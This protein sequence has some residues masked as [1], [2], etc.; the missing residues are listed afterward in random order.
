VFS[1]LSLGLFRFL[2][3][4]FNNCLMLLSRRLSYVLVMCLIDLLRMGFSNGLLMDFSN[5]LSMIL[6]NGLRM[7]L[8]NGLRVFLDDVLSNGLRMNFDDVLSNGLRVSLSFVLMM[9]LSNGL[10][11]SLSYVLMM[12]LSNGLRVNLSYVLLVCFSDVLRMGFSNGLMMGF[13]LHYSNRLRMDVSMNLSIGRSMNLN[14]RL[15][16]CITS[17]LM[18]DSFFNRF[19]LSRRFWLSN[20][21]NDLVNRLRF[22]NLNHLLTVLNDFG[23]AM[24]LKFRFGVGSGELLFLLF[25]LVN[26]FLDVGPRFSLNSGLELS[27]LSLKLLLRFGDLCVFSIKSVTVFLFKVDT[28]L[29]IDEGEN[30]AIV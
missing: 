25:N 19:F 4:G 5:L 24:G 9:G 17:S 3:F 13:S 28:D 20:F 16:V 12:C 26:D 7:G 1:S 15:I 22:I 18:I 29:V 10:R 14:H 23:L 6:S 2:S 11:E 30:H 27:G 8:S 21:L